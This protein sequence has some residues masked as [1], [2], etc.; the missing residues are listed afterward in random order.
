MGVVG[1]GWA[2]LG[3]KVVKRQAKWWR[4]GQRS[5]WGKGE[6]LHVVNHTKRSPHQTLAGDYE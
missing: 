1:R 4:A 5:E 2:E 6:W 3:D